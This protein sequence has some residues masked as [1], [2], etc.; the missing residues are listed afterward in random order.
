MNVEQAERFQQLLEEACEH[1]IEYD[2]GTIV[3]KSFDNYSGGMCPMTCL[4]GRAPIMV[5]AEEAN[6]LLGTTTITFAEIWAL[7]DA[8]D[9]VSIH[10]NYNQYVSAILIGRALREKYI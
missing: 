10:E 9:G 6:H 5:M 4:F 8:F 2:S 1:H 7:I 3:A